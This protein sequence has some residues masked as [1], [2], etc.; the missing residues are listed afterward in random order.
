MAHTAAQLYNCEELTVY[1]LS[2][3]HSAAH[4]PAQ[5]LGDRLFFLAGKTRFVCKIEESVLAL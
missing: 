1:V 3:D 2:D 5:A 4:A